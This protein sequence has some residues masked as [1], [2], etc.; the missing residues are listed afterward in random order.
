MAQA[1]KVAIAHSHAAKVKKPSPLRV[2]ETSLKK[3]ANRTSIV[4][5]PT[6]KQYTPGTEG[7]I[8]GRAADVVV[9]EEAGIAVADAADAAEVVETVAE[10]IAAIAN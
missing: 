10:E 3:R 6:A 1:L 4:R 7:L 2:E 8:A 5:T 9:E